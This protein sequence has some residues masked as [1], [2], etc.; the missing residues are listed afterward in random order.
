MLRDEKAR[1]ETLSR[2]CGARSRDNGL[3]LAQHGAKKG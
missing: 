2:A 1:W 3:A